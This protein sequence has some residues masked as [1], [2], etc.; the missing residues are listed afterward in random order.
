MAISDGIRKIFLAGVGAAATTGEEAKN[1]IDTLAEKGEAAVEQGKAL[2]EEL[3]KNTKE[4]VNRR[5]TVHVVNEFKDV[6]SAVE[7]MS[8]EELESLK[9]R[10]NAMTADEEAESG[11]VEADVQKMAAQETVAQPTAAQGMTVQEGEATEEEQDASG[12]PEQTGD[13]NENTQDEN[14]PS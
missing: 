9:E 1:L 3:K 11:E 8:K 5:V 4:K 12:S 14:I 2:N 10:L 13:S 6:Y 7:K